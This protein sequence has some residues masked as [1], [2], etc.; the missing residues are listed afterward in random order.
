MIDRTELRVEKNSTSKALIRRLFSAVFLLVE[1][2]EQITEGELPLACSIRGGQKYAPW[3]N[4]LF[5]ELAWVR[6]GQPGIGHTIQPRA[7]WS[8]RLHP[9]AMF[10]LQSLG[11]LFQRSP[12]GAFWFVDILIK[13]LLQGRFDR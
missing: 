7:L 8:V 6:R 5:E 9:L 4:S 2:W 13:A 10:A 1:K 11:G 12:D 3:I